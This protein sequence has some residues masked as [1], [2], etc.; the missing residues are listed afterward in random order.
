MLNLAVVVDSQHVHGLAALNGEAVG[1]L[2][3]DAGVVKNIQQRHQ[4]AG[5]VRHLDGQDLG[6]RG[7]EAGVVEHLIGLLRPVGDNPRHAIV[8]GV[9]HGQGMHR[10]VGIGQDPAKCSQ[11]AFGVF[12]KNGY[13]L[14]H[15]SSF[16]HLFVPLVDY[17]LGLA[18]AALYGLR[19]GDFHLDADLQVAAQLG[20]D[21]LL[22][23]L[24][25]ANLVEVELRH[26]LNL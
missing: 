25:L 6:Q 2:N 26:G 11:T 14:Y 5:V 1:V 13:L 16:P 20:V 22:Q 24:Y 21:A 3:I 15:R 7:P 12:Q 18:L 17:A 8:G 10:D 19:L 23:L 9:G 4:A